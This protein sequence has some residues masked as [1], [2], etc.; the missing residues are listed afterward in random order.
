MNSVKESSKDS[1]FVFPKRPATALTGAIMNMKVDN[2]N[3]DDE[4]Q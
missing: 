1:K 3:D 4:S 2:N